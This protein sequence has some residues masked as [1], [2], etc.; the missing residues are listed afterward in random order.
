MKQEDFDKVF[1]S[2]FQGFTSR[3]WLYYMDEN[4]TPFSKTKDYAGYVI[5]NFKYLVKRFNKENDE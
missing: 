5:N 2:K 3:L 1:T 4:N